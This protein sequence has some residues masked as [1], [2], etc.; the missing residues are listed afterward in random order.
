MP[1]LTDLDGSRLAENEGESWTILLD[2]LD[3]Y[4][5]E[6]KVDELIRTEPGRAAARAWLLAYHERRRL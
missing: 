3:L 6:R 1:H 5:T 4:I 2:R